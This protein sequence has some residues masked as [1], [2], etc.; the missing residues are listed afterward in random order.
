MNKIVAF[1]LVS[2]SSF[3][4]NQAIWIDIPKTDGE[5]IVNPNR[6]TGTKGPKAKCTAI[7]DF[8]FQMAKTVYATPTLNIKNEFKPNGFQT[9]RVDLPLDKSFTELHERIF[10]GRVLPSLDI[11]SDRF[12]NGNVQS[13]TQHIKLIN[14]SLLE[15]SLFTDI[16]VRQSVLLKYDKIVISSTKLNQNGG[17][18]KV[19]QTCL[20][21]KTG[22][23]CIDKI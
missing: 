14:V 15:I 11:F 19:E 21:L 1:L 7:I 12:S 17:I 4:Q 5:Y 18:L 16:P 10:E 22:N 9:L 20:D 8:E 3:A 23:P 6:L 2:I 13:E